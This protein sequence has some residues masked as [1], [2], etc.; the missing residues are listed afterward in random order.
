M[1][2]LGSTTPTTF[3]EGL[4][5]SVLGRRLGLVLPEDVVIAFHIV[6]EGGGE[7]QVTRGE[8]FTDVGPL[9]A[10]P[11]DCEVY[12]SSDEFMGIV[13]GEVDA[14]ES[15]LDGRLQVLGDIGLVIRI[16]K[17]LRTAA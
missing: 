9:N 13:S 4:L 12:C 6:G 10:G 2:E 17:M 8:D 11:K 3:F 1:K 7:W 14:T 5:R 16:Q 15:F